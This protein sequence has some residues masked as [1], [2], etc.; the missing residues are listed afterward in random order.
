MLPRLRHGIENRLQ[1]RLV[2]AR[3]AGLSRAGGHEQHDTER[4]EDAKWVRVDSGGCEGHGRFD[5]GFR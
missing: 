2:V 1:Q 5:A 3:F 4:R